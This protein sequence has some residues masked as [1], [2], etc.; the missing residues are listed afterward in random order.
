MK[1]VPIIR[2]EV[3]SARRQIVHLLQQSGRELQEATEAALKSELDRVF[4]PEALQ[5]HVRSI[6][7]QYVDQAI[8]KAVE[9]YFS[10]GNGGKSVRKAAHAILDDMFDSE[11]PDT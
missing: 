10:Y 7:K 3:E 11:L 2:V 6:A 5:L 1:S 4:D 9:S 8:K